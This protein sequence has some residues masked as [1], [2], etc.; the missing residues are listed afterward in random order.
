M[1][2]ARER[3]AWDKLSAFVLHDVKNA[4]TML[5]LASENAADHIQKPEFQQDM[6]EAVNDALKRMTKV[7]DRLS[8]LKEEV[9]P[10]WQDM[11]LRQFLEDHCAQLGKKLGAMD[12]ALDCRT[13]IRVNS[14]PK[15]FS[16][17]G[18]PAAQCTGGRR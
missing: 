12:I 4:A 10:V 17:P 14:D 15:L 2:H 5:A 6:L 3:R 11:E 16:H 7:Q 9:A 1:A 18:K 13:S 8:M